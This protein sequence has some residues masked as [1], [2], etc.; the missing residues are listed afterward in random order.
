MT[1]MLENQLDPIDRRILHELTKD[2]RIA[3]TKLAKKLRVSNTLVHQRIKKMKTAGIL[4]KAVY[5]LD[6]WKLGYQTSAYTQI[7][8]K[9][10]KHHRSVEEQLA[11]IP[12]IV[13]CVNIA[14][15]Y[16]L[17]VKIYAK[18]NRNLRDI[19]YEKILSIEGVEGTN[20]TIAFETAFNR[21]IPM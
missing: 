16:A 11:K 9:E 4:D 20:T 3:Y 13:E 19:V 8:L 14:G 7:M 21:T 10:A 12:E 17:L 2:A 18:D 6:A 1:I 15:R 5:Q